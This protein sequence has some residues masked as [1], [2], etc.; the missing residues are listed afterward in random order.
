VAL[1]VVIVH[2]GAD[3]AQRVV[4]RAPMGAASAIQHLVVIIQENHSFD[5]YFGRWCEAAP[6]SNPACTEGPR[7]CEAGPRS[8]PGASA[9]VVLDDA[10]N[11]AYGP[12]HDRACELAEMNGGKMD[13]FVTA[14]CGSPRNFAYAGAAASYYLGL[15]ARYALAD[16][17]FQPV[18]GAS[19]ANDMYFA[20]ARWV[21]D[22]NDRQPDAIGLRCQR[23][24]RPLAIEAPTIGDLLAAAG[25]GWAFYAEGYAAMVSAEAQGRCPPIPP[26]C[27]RRVEGYPCTYDPGD[28]PFA[29]A[30]S[31]RD[32]P[33][34]FKDLSD[35]RTSLTAGAL[36]EVSFVKAIG[37]RTEH[38]GDGTIRAGEAFVSG[39]VEQI[40]ASPRY[41][42]STLVLVTWDESGGYF[43]HVTPPP[44]S[45][46]DGQPYGPRVPLL[47]IGAFARKNHVSHVVMEHASIV[48]F[49]EWRWL[50]ATGQLGGRDAEVNNLGSLLDP[51][52]TGA[53]VPED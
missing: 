11:L 33:A 10:E 29:F 20:R 51:A 27:P 19:S 40:L 15:A 9:P 37:Y 34:H 2:A 43:D 8:T 6:G 38:P 36:P 25:I 50:G 45:R 42:P 52:K 30:A 21:F 46:V 18:A 17:Y 44:A 39:L 5:A 14:P 4:A 47:A 32:D 28:D 12:R 31:L 24:R 48:T 16:R 1:L 35:L 53:V 13:R 3:T 41:A 26:D 23:G 49:I 7:C 22:D